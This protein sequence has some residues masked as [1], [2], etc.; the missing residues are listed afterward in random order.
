MVFCAVLCCAVMVHV[1]WWWCGLY[2]G[3]W[4]CCGVVVCGICGDGV[5]C[6]LVW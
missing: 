4:W 3:L 6:A 2:G 1:V 5:F